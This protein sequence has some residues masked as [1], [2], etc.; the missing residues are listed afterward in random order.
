VIASVIAALGKT[1]NVAAGKS[2]GVDLGSRNNGVDNRLR[3]SLLAHDPINLFAIMIEP[4]EAFIGRSSG[5][6]A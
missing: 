3:E 6:L 5:E 4:L 1:E 2:E